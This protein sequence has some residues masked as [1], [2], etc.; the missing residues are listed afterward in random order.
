MWFVK[1]VNNPIVS[2]ICSVVWQVVSQ[3]PPEVPKR[4][5]ELVIAVAP[6]NEDKS[7]KFIYVLNAL[8]AEY[9]D[10]PESVVR[11][12]IESCVQIAKKRIDG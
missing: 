9:P 10:L 5:L 8:R 2:Q 12:L 4:A 11:T 1:L 7:V 3:I 6:R